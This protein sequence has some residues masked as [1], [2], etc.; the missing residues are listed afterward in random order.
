ME[1]KFDYRD[2][3]I[4]PRFISSVDSRSQCIPLQC[5]EMYKTAEN[6]SVTRYTLPIMAAP[7]DTVISMDNFSVFCGHG[8][9]PCI[10]RNISCDKE[11][12]IRL[13]PFKHEIFVSFGM[14]ENDSD[15]MEE[16]IKLCK[17][18]C[19]ILI[20][21]A[22]GHM[23]KLIRLSSTLKIQYPDIKLMIGNIANPHT[24]FDAALAKVDYIRVGIGA[25]N[26]CTTSA[27]AGVHYPM[28]SLV[29]E[30]YN[31]KKENNLNIKI[32]ADGGIRNFD[33]AI[34]AL[35]LGA[36]YVMAGSIFNKCIESA[37]DNYFKGIY[38]G[39]RLGNFL[40]S[41]GFKIEK[42]Y[43]GMSTK[44]AQKNMGNTILKTSEGVSKKQLV[45]C[46]ISKWT[47]NFAS[48]LRT[49]MSYTN[50]TSLTEF[51][52]KVNLVR[53]TSLARSRFEK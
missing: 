4:V 38:V 14:S 45:N 20:D 47:D 36:D 12:L 25:G 11:N 24:V 13:V 9:I 16:Y 18:K 17:G 26:A 33:D 52:G 39:K 21:V 10:P 7:M 6:I 48:Y 49:T 44:E 23:K 37:G 43:R 3:N 53:I 5:F 51:I 27:N 40:F 31:V 32:V 50:T 35:A 1:E 30:C 22:N 8:I 29:Q 19:N 34:K 46:T 42:S 2:V 28:G 15:R 41:H